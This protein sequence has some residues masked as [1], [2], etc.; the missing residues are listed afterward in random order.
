M[1]VAVW[2]TFAARPGHSEAR[3]RSR[4]GERFPAGPAAPRDAN[5]IIAHVT[6]GLP[7]V[8]CRRGAYFVE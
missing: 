4:R 2:T 7:I 3:R 1:V 8:G 6:E 5:A